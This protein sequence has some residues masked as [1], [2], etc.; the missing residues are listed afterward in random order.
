M[1]KF[2]F[3]WWATVIFISLAILG[4]LGGASIFIR[5]DYERRRGQGHDKPKAI[6]L[7]LWDH[8][9]VDLLRQFVL[10]VIALVALILFLG[11]FIGLWIIG[12]EK[13]IEVFKALDGWSMAVVSLPMF[14]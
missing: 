5:Q 4:F 11:G 8:L 13:F 1:E 3:E 6:A 12:W 9:V 14:V 7:A 2:S 10:G